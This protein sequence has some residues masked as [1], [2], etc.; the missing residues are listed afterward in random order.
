MI[1]ISKSTW[2]DISNVGENN[3]FDPL[4]S[5]FYPITS[6]LSSLEIIS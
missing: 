5:P 2:S 4:E 1:F 6:W 3:M